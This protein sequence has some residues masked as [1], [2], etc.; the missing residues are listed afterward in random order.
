MTAEVDMSRPS[1]RFVLPYEPEYT[2]HRT[3]QR[4]IRTTELHRAARQGAIGP[5][6]VPAD[7]EWPIDRTSRRGKPDL[8]LERGAM[9]VPPR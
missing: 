8:A 6:L 3:D 2:A 7:P 4:A 9:L 5:T 1:K